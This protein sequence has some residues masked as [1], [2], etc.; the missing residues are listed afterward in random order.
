MVESG[1]DKGKTFEIGPAMLVA[2]RQVGVDILLNDDQISRRH[3]SFEEVNNVLFLNDL[4]SANGTRLNGRTISANQPVSL[5]PGD[6]I[7]IGRTTLLVQGGQ[8][9]SDPFRTEVA[10]SIPPA[11]PI[12]TP[13]NPAP[14]YSNSPASIYPNE[15]QGGYYQQPNNGYNNPAQ[16]PAYNNNP[17]PYNAQPQQAYYQPQPPAPVAPKKGS[18]AP[19][20]I[21]VLAIVVVAAVAIGAILFISKG[22]PT[23]TPTV[24][25]STTGTPS[26]T[27]GP[28]Q[29]IKQA[30]VGPSG[31]NGLP[32]APPDP[33][34]ATPTPN[35]TTN[36]GA[37]GSTTA[38]GISV[39][40][41]TDWKTTVDESKS[42]IESD[43]PDGVTFSLIYRR[44]G[45]SGTAVDRLSAY[46][47]DIEPNITNFTLTQE[48]KF[49]SS[50]NT[51]ADAYV[52]FTDK[53]G[54]LLQRD[55]ILATNNKAGDTYFI[56]FST[57][58]ASFDS[59]ISTFN[60]ILQSIVIN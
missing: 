23:T 25:G 45:L 14:A 31:S 11:P 34:A 16:P 52:T 36:P 29:P 19:I 48:P 46:L 5:T 42:V 18:A 47:Q 43:A 55:Y 38:L 24:Q 40:Y 58:D 4:G 30:M 7:Q 44:S 51:I 13:A 12:I 1:P 22:S 54:K 20:I 59:Q 41:P 57:E 35:P 37:A 49:T 2:G 39:K 15:P 9:G 26:A 27:Q 33:N 28:D 53:D 17:N 3:A 10:G 21:G 8:A 60:S 32:P 56:H 50:D 6:R